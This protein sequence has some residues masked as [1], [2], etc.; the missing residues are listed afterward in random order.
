MADLKI[1]PSTMFDNMN[2]PDYEFAEFPMAIPV[3]DGVIQP[4]PYDERHKAH[5]V[6]IV[7]SQAELEALKGPEVKLVAV[8]PHDPASTLRVESEDDIR[9]ALYVQADQ[10]GVKIDKRW[11][12]ERIE[13]ALQDHAAGKAAVI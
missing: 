11:S 12:V 7:N 3:V 5:P 2:F 10:A 6:V 4:T 13:Q 1:R 9:A 8:N